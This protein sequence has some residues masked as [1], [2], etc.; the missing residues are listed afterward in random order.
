[1]VTIH[2]TDE[3][4]VD[5]LEDELVTKSD[6]YLMRDLSHARIAI[7]RFDYLKFVEEVGMS[8]DHITRLMTVTDDMIPMPMEFDGVVEI[9]PSV[10]QGVGIFSTGQISRGALICP[11]RIG[12]KRTPA[13]RYTNH[14]CCPNAEMRWADGGNINLYALDDIGSDVEITANYRVCKIA[15]ERALKEFSK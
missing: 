13:G 7:D 3:T 11:T 6:A 14:S 12:L 15:A 2:P 9:R 5:K 8:H 1:L 10:V 4:D